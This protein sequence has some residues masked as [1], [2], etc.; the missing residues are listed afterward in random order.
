MS[1]KSDT[2]EET[3][4]YRP[5]PVELM[6]GI[7]EEARRR[8]KLA[9]RGDEEQGMEELSVAPSF[10]EPIGTSLKYPEKKNSYHFSEFTRHDGSTFIHSAFWGLLGRAPETTALFAYSKLLGRGRSKLAILAAIHCSEE[11]RVRDVDL[12]G[13]SLVLLRQRIIRRLG[14]FGKILGR[15]FDPFDRC[16]LW[17]Y[18]TPYRHEDLMKIE[19]QNSEN[20]RLIKEHTEL[21]WKLGQNQLRELQIS[22]EDCKLELLKQKNEFNQYMQTIQNE[23]SQHHE[24]L[25]KRVEELEIENKKLTM[26]S[27]D[28]QED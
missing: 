20:Y 13:M 21:T 11:G 24:T 2:K 26:Q 23:A 19:R 22:L 25:L 1:L 14:R 10:P 5:N 8:A 17:L 3:I 4:A 15:C 28:D 27:R 9:I 6:N 12:V 16:F 18:G 7:R